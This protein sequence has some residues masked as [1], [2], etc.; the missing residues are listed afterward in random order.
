VHILIKPY[1]IGSIL[2]KLYCTPFFISK[3]I[4]FMSIK[5]FDLKKEGAKT[6][7]LKVHQDKENKV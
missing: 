4:I 6:K 2:D 3:M 1:A 5:R 7:G